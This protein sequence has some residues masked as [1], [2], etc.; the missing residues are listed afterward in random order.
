MAIPF[1]YNF[2]SVNGEVELDLTKTTALDLIRLASNNSEDL[3]TD[4]R[5]GDFEIIDRNTELLDAM[6]ESH[7][8]AIINGDVPSMS[9][10]ELVKLDCDYLH[11]ARSLG[12]YEFD[13]DWCDVPGDMQEEDSHLQNWHAIVECPGASEVGNK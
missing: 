11:L 10:A 2:S 5:K 9:S 13:D 3:D 7:T 8:M 12:Y 4:L 1:T 6:R